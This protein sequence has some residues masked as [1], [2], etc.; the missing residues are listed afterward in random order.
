MERKEIFFDS[1]QFGVIKRSLNVPLNIAKS[2]AKL[3]TEAGFQVNKDNISDCLKLQREERRIKQSNNI[4]YIGQHPENQMQM[5]VCETIFI[6]NEHLQAE[7]DSMLQ[8]SLKGVIM[9]VF[10]KEREETAKEDFWM[11]QSRIYNMVHPFPDAMPGLNYFLKWF[12]VEGD[13][14]VLPENVDELIKEESTTYADDDET[15]QILQ[16]HDEAVDALN[17]LMEVFAFD[18]LNTGFILVGGKVAR[19]PINY[20]LYLNK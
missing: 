9:P 12:D 16:L 19:R 11:L 20:K 4:E 5:Y 15:I 2:V 1:S 6:N 14:V 13:E 3:L 18:D 17:K 8:K 10:R 7:F